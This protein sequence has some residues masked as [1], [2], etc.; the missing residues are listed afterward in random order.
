MFSVF[1]L[2]LDG[3]LWALSV[4]RVGVSDYG[5]LVYWPFFFLTTRQK[6]RWYIRRRPSR[7][8]PI[9]KRVGEY[10]LKRGEMALGCHLCAHLN[11]FT[12]DTLR[13]NGVPKKDV[14]LTST[15]FV[16]N[17]WDEVPGDLRRSA[18]SGP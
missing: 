17:L 5:V 6:R 11:V 8:L 14:K 3:G 10:V 13:S 18:H 2:S 1:V 7:P 16:D 4:F 12:M 15:G 9:E